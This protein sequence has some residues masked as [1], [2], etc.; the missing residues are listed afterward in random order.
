MWGVVGRALSLAVGKDN[1]GMSPGCGAESKEW[2]QRRGL[3]FFAPSSQSSS[4]QEMQAAKELR[5]PASPDR[6]VG[7]LV[8]LRSSP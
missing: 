2:E 8:A 6:A 3:G 1:P 7:S 5:S 4:S